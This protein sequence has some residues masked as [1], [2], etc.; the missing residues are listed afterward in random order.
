MKPKGFGVSNTELEHFFK[1]N[2]RNL[3][4][5]FVGVFLADKKRKFFDEVSGKETKYLF[6]VPNT[7]LARKLRIHWW[8][9]LDTDQKGTLYLFDSL[10]IYVL[11]N[12]IVNNDLDVFKCVIPGQI[13]QILKKGNKITFLRWSFK[14]NNYKKLKQ[15]QLD[16]LTPAAKHFLKFLYDFGKYKNIKNTVKVDKVEDNLQSFDT[17]YCSPFQMYFYVS[18]FEPLK[19]SVVAESSSKKLDV[20][21]RC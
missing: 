12:F 19:G 7:D 15:K 3:L 5:N 4:E 18:L 20:K 9:L 11:L 10:G 21:E 2:R 6:M 16:K 13:K 1:N 14:L 17:D 8:S